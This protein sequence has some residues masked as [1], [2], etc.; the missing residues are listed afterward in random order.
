LFPVYE[1]KIKEGAQVKKVRLVCNGKTQQNPGATY[2]PTPSREEFH[3][4]LHIIAHYD[5]EF[6]HMDES[7]AFLS[8]S[9]K[10]ETPVVARIHGFHKFYKVHGALYGLKSSPRHYRLEVV[11]RLEKMGFTRLTTSSCIFVYRPD[12]QNVVFIFVFVD[13][14]IITGTSRDLIQEAA[15]AYRKVATTT[16]LIWDPELVLGHRIQRNRARRIILI[17]LESKIT[18][19]A[20][21]LDCDDAKTRQTPLPVSGYVLSDEE[22]ES[23]T[24]L[25]SEF[26]NSAEKQLYQQIIGSLIWIYGIRYDILF[27]VMYLTWQSQSPRRHHLE[28]AYCVM[29]YLYTTR[30]DPLVLGGPDPIQLHGYS[31]ASYGTGKNRRSIVSH[32]VRLNSSAGAIFAKTHLS[33]YIRTSSFECELEGYTILAKS[34]IRF[35]N[36]LSALGLDVQKAQSFTDNKAMLDFAKGEGEAKGIRHMEI[37]M[38]YI[39]EL[40][41]CAMFDANHM[42]G[43]IIPTD[44][45]TKI[46]DRTQQL[47]FKKEVLGHRL[48]DD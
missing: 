21:S 2:S 32:L 7:R 6:C 36:I 38:F 17:D 47:A 33:R 11:E 3:L 23:S 26:L 13:D 39:R 19:V 5:W 12:S 20:E 10:G 8:A 43:K 16:P 14:F 44:F 25:S 28:M 31:D 24:T 35:I 18:E 46:A 37:R 40:L 29:V 41:S 30:S 1:E 22:F 34:L 48:L 42:S 27:A 45:M 4:L 9:Y 15:D